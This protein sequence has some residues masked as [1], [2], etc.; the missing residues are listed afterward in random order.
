[1]S[2]PH[3][4]RRIGLGDM[5]RILSRPH[6]S[7]VLVSNRPQPFGLSDLI[8]VMDN[9]LVRAILFAHCRQGFG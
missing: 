2:L 7:I 6:V 8:R 5:S 1:M 3:S 4:L 9:L